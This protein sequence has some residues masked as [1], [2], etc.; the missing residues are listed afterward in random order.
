MSAITLINLHQCYLWKTNPQHSS[1][2]QTNHRRVVV[3]QHFTCE[4]TEYHDVWMV[5]DGERCRLP[6]ECSVTN[7]ASAVS[8]CQGHEWLFTLLTLQAMRLTTPRAF[9]K[10]TKTPSCQPAQSRAFPVTQESCHSNQTGVAPTP[11]VSDYHIAE[12]S[13][14][15]SIYSLSAAEQKGIRLHE[16]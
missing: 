4:M 10:H 1:Y 6:A 15:R 11:G 3:L 12:R 5:A 16:R 8:V 2:K 9:S 7:N 13:S 14:S